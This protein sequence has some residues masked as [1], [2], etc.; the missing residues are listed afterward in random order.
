MQRR[1]KLFLVLLV[2]ILC[3]IITMIVQLLP[4]IED[5]FDKDVADADIASYVKSIGWRGFP[6][7]AGL[8]ALQVI[9][10]VIPAAAT[11]VLTGLCYGLVWGP[12]IFLGGI[13]LGNIFVVFTIRE[14]GRLFSKRKK[15]PSK[16]KSHL[17]IEELDKIKR[18]EIVAFFLFMIPFISGAGPYLFAETK[19]PMGRYLLAVITGSIPSAILYIF[20]GERISSGSYTTAIITAA[21]I[22]IAIV[23]VLVFK[24]QI[25]AKI[26][27]SGS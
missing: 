9:I 10:P 11:G 5:I 13:A 8:S 6:A 20:L 12:L 25:M 27:D 2:L 7:L 14:L 26:M 23:L 19:V 24:K 3:T 17:S 1:E 18:P 21:V 4:I 16:H 22:V 15:Q